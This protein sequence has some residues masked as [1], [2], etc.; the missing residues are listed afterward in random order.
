RHTWTPQDLAQLTVAGNSIRRGEVRREELFPI[1]QRSSAA[2]DEIA[3]VSDKAP[4][5]DDPSPITRRLLSNVKRQLAAERNLTVPSHPDTL[6]YVGT[7]VEREITKLDELTCG[8]AHRVLA[9]LT[10][11]KE[12]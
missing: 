6:Q 3:R 2:G 11:T 12:N 5:T 9:A 4:A 1:V 7:V 10:T 8:E